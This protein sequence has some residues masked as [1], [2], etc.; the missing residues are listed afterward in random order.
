MHGVFARARRALRT[1]R[2]L[3]LASFLMCAGSG[4][5]ACS[6]K[7]TEEQCTTLVNHLI[8]LEVQAA[9]TGK[10]PEQMKADVEK[11]KQEI[12]EYVGK[13][14]VAKCLESLPLSVVKCGIA[15]RTLEEHAACDKK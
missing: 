1:A 14:A 8:D 9:G 5:L 7:P 10:L 2:F 3:G 12:A 4:L 13:E 11:Q 15:A 6:N